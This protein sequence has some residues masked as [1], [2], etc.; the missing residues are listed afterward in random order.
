M[1]LLTSQ[2]RLLRVAAS[3]MLLWLFS[4]VVADAAPTPRRG[5]VGPVCDAQTLTLKWLRLPKSFGGPLKAPRRRAV[6]VSTDTTARVGRARIVHRSGDGAI[7]QND[8]PAARVDACDRLVPSL[9]L[10]G[11]FSGAVAMRPLSR[12]FSPRSPRGPPFAA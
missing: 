9:R 8:A 11:V 7:I 3:V 12:T 2:G 4:A 10:L 1:P 6:M 5:V